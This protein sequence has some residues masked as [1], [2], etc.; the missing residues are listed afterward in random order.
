[1]ESQKMNLT[2]PNYWKR[3]VNLQK[4]WPAK[5]FPN[6]AVKKQ[7]SYDFNN[8]NTIFDADTAV[9]ENLDLMVKLTETVHSGKKGSAYHNSTDLSNC[10]LKLHAKGF[11]FTQGMVYSDTY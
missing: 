2:V 1:M 7:I 3:W 8:V 4:A 9:V 10:I 5:M 6:P 11:T